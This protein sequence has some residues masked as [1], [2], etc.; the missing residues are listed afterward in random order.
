MNDIKRPNDN[1]AL[2]GTRASVKSTDGMVANTD[3]KKK[4]KK[5][6]M[7]KPKLLTLFLVLV[8]LAL[9]A[10]SF[11][12]Y[13]KYNETKKEVEKLST[14]Q[15]QQELNKT[16]VN[17]LL[18]EMRAIIVLPKGEDPVVA[19][20]TDVS[21]LNKNAFYKEAQN[22][23]RVVVFAEAKKAFIYRP[24]T[25]TIINVGSFQLDQ[26]SQKQSTQNKNPN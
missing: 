22:G 19:T 15:G 10:G 23:D 14:V 20:I 13:K 24:S 9:A 5:K 18:G 21:K 17:Q 3:N 7:R 8:L 12:L 25:K 1:D 4:D 6:R 26:Q 11:F 16:Q 2:T